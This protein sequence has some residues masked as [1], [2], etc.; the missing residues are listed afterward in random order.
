MMSE[1]NGGWCWL[2]LDEH[3]GRLYLRAV[4]VREM[5]LGLLGYT[6]RGCRVH[7]EE[8]LESAP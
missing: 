6:Q 2:V 3:N 7:D 1:N 8:I 5:V 4:G